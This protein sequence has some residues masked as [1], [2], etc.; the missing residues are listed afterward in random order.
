MTAS[1]PPRFALWVL[2][3]CGVDN[4]SL[5]GDLIEEY[6][7][8]RSQP[9]LWRQVLGAILARSGPGSHTGPLGIGDARLVRSAPG[10]ASRE[11]SRI[12]LGVG[13]GR[14]VPASRAPA[15]G[16][17]PRIDLSAGPVPGIGGL[18]TLALVFQVTLVSPQLLWLPVFGLATG[19]L[20]GLALVARHRREPYR[21][22]S[23]APR[24]LPGLR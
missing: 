3:R 2:R 20:V 1:R 6:G 17:R 11:R 19:S 12:D 14:T 24:V 15:R 10:P 22:T 5:V 23:A 18:T 13:R 16:Q 21:A 4:K 7:A 9:W 8:R